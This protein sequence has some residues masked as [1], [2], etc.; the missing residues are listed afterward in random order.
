MVTLD[1]S[2]DNL[3]RADIAKVA[4]SKEVNTLFSQ[5]HIGL[6]I[7][8][9]LAAIQMPAETLAALEALD[10]DITFSEITDDTQ[11]ANTNS[12]LLQ[13]AAGGKMMSNP[14][15]IVTNYAKSTR[16]TL[17]IDSKVIPADQ[18][19]LDTFIASLAVLVEHSDGEI[20]LQKGTLTYDANGKPIAISI[21]V[22][23]FSTIP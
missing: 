10:V 7:I 22:D 18:K 17:P 2:S 23:K 15:R 13:L 14:I 3:E 9:D 12:L 21:W 19:E 16:V 8:T 6:N 11:I 20:R 1:L 4:F 5:N